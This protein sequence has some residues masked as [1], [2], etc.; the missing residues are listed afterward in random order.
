MLSL[1]FVPMKLN[2][3]KLKK[4]IIE[5][6]VI[7]N[8]AIFQVL[9]NLPVKAKVESEMDRPKRKKEL[10]VKLHEP[11]Q[12]AKKA[13][14]ESPFITNNEAIPQVQQS[15]NRDKL[16]MG[17]E[18]CNKSKKFQ[19]ENCWKSFNSKDNYNLFLLYHFH[20]YLETRTYF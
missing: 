3:L 12:I 11:E 16:Q 4:S 13:K 10:P 18:D 14:V 9:I 1:L 17:P 6:P 20:D 8:E 2:L 7:A 19:C 5:S 15:N